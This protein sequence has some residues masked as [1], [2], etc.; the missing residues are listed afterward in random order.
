M[1]GKSDI[2]YLVQIE[3]KKAVTNS[4]DTMLG[5]QIKVALDEGSEKKDLHVNP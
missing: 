2:G 1:F 4:G 5:S 3:S